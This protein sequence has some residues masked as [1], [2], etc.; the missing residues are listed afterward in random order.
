MS[1]KADG[2]DLSMIVQE[3]AAG[4]DDVVKRLEKYVVLPVFDDSALRG[5]RVDISVC[6]QYLRYFVGCRSTVL[7]NLLLQVVRSHRRQQVDAAGITQV[8]QCHTKSFLVMVTDLKPRRW[9]SSPIQRA[10]NDFAI[11]RRMINF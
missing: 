2:H 11:G 3:W 7:V 4:I 1:G 5:N 8:G 10:D 6:S 9:N